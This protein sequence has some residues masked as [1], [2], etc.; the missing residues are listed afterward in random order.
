M[1]FEWNCLTPKWQTFCERAASA[2][3]NISEGCR[4]LQF[5]KNW[6]DSA[7]FFL[8]QRTNVFVEKLTCNVLVQHVERS[9]CTNRLSTQK[10]AQN[11]LKPKILN[12]FNQTG[13]GSK[14]WKPRPCVPTGRSSMTARPYS[15]QH[16][17]NNTT[18]NVQ[19]TFNERLH[20]TFCLHCAQVH[21]L[22]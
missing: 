19:V 1:K 15:S 18:L 14:A 11:I 7:L 13:S 2:N 20:E 5:P 16:S 3:W 22:A 6:R 17:V 4:N 21:R 10:P 9:L 12:V 8:I